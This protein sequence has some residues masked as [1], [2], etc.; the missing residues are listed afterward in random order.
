VLGVFQ[1]IFVEGENREL[2]SRGG[3]ADKASPLQY[4]A[5]YGILLP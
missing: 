5:I 1:E 3:G 4:V 2:V